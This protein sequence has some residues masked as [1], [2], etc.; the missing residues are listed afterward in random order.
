VLELHTA[1]ADNTAEPDELREQLAR[2]ADSATAA[3]DELREVSRGIHPAMLSQ[4]GLGPALRVLSR[5]SAIPVDL[6]ISTAGRLPERIE[7]ATYYVICELLT[8]AV[9]HA[10]ASIVRVAV[11]QRSEMLHLEIRDDGVGG[12]DPAG[13]SGLIGLRD[14]VEALGGTIVVESPLG[15][16]TDVRVSL[17]LD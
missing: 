3:L 12:A 11:E 7:V 16:G 14:R 8:N 2:A 9:K 5:R 10:R 1:A 13:G 6:R 17:P 4:G 15:A